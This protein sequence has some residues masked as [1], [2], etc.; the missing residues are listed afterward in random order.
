MFDTLLAFDPCFV[1]FDFA[2]STCKTAY[3]IFALVLVLR[4]TSAGVT[5]I[6]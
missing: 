4:G 2:F 5:C 1:A 3:A 6:Y